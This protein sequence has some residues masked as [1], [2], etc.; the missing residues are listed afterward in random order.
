MGD[1][2]VLNTFLSYTAVGAGTDLAFLL[3]QDPESLISALLAASLG[4]TGKFVVKW[5]LSAITGAP[6]GFVA[7]GL[8]RALVGYIVFGALGGLPGAVTLR[9]L[10]KAG[11][12]AY[13]EEKR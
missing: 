8:A 13:L 3:L 9:A 1:F 6:A 12:T 2:G 4:H 10:A 11:F 5:A 7:P